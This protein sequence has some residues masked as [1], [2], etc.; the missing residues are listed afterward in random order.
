MRLFRGGF[1]GGG[2]TVHRTGANGSITAVGM[3]AEEVETEGLVEELG[4][5]ALL[6]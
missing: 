4:G 3:G 1:N 6:E 2:A 5:A